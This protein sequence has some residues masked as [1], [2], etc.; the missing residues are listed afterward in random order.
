MGCQSASVFGSQTVDSWSSW[1]L[2]PKRVAVRSSIWISRP[3]CRSGSY[4]SRTE[5]DQPANTPK[6]SKRLFLPFLP[7]AKI[8]RT[9]IR[10]RIAVGQGAV[11]RSCDIPERVQSWPLP[12][13]P[14]EWL[15]MA[16]CLAADGACGSIRRSQQHLR[17]CSLAVERGFQTKGCR[18]YAEPRC[19]QAPL[20]AKPA[21]CGIQDSSS[22][23]G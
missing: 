13:N 18:R 9:R 10:L 12:S 23:P 19:R 15:F 2:R 8:N 7:Y 17:E 11:S 5:P 20:L 4:L 22:S 3:G 21:R 16:S 14:R 6:A 1:N